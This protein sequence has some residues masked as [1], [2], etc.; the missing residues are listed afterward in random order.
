MCYLYSIVSL[1]D[2]DESALAPRRSA[3]ADHDGC[4][5]NCCNA[6]FQRVCA[7]NSHHVCIEFVFDSLLCLCWFS[8]VAVALSCRDMGC[9][10]GG[11]S[12]YV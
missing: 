7:D 4:G 10:E 11:P 6:D 2:N 5:E 8:T 1:T 12:A 3:L 9:A